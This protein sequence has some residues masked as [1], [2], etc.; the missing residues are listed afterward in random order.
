[1]TRT[2]GRA[3]SAQGARGCRGGDRTRAHGPSVAPAPAHPDEPDRRSH[4]ARLRVGR[5]PRTGA[6]RRAR[7]AGAHPA[8][9]ARTG[10]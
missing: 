9:A 7:R 4:D 10:W 2:A 1:M 6:R 3:H 5:D 8:G